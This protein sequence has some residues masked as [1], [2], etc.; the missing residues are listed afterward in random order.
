M[1]GMRRGASSPASGDEVMHGLRVQLT[2]GAGR[3]AT[4][5]PLAMQRDKADAEAY[6]RRRN[7][8]SA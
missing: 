3:A 2:G 1:G 8:V 7:T 4:G 5:I 6:L